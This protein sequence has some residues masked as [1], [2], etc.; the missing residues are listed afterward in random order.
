MGISPGLG[1]IP[2]GLVESGKPVFGFPTF[3]APA[4]P[5]L[6]VLIV[7]GSGLRIENVGPTVTVG[8]G[9]AGRRW[10]IT[11]SSAQARPGLE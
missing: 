1:E 9:C 4:F 2:K 11:S 5:Q 3:H 10:T 8:G 7:V 6:S